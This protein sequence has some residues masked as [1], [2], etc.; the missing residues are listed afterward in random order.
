MFAHFRPLFVAFLSLALGIYVAELFREGKTIYTYIIVAVIAILIVLSLFHFSSKSKF[1]DYLWK[2]IKV[3]VVFAVFVVI[4]FS[5][6]T[7]TKFNIESQQNI[8]VNSSI[9]YNIVGELRFSPIKYENRMTM[10]LDEVTLISASESIELESSGMY[11]VVNTTEINENSKLFSARAGDVVL[12]N[13]KVKNSDVFSKNDVFAYAYKSNFRYTAYVESD[14]LKII[15]GTQSGID[16]VRQY[17]KD[18]FYSSMDARYA[19]L[20]YALFI[21]DVSGIDYDMQL[22]FKYSGIAHLLAVSGLNTALLAMVLMW[23]FKRCKIKPKYGVLFVALFLA[24]YCVLCDFAPSVMRA[25]LMSVFLLLGQAFGK[26]SDNISSVSLAGIIL[27]LLSPMFLFDL[28]F[29]LSLPVTPI[30]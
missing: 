20:A 9:T 27:L 28:S 2:N 7:I 19:G 17:L 25:S 3:I 6:F 1:F 26:Q 5:S 21:G 16:R 24:F 12:L 29:L 10:F 14:C 11:V 8:R 13:G 4:G 15:D 23:I 30:P 22:N 18:I